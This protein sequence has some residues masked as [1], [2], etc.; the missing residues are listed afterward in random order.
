M[1]SVAMA[2]CEEGETANAIP[3]LEQQLI[4]AKVKLPARP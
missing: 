3:V 1:A 2:D 4:N